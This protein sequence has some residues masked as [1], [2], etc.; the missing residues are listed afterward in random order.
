MNFK[1]ETI[2]GRCIISIMKLLIYI[3]LPILN[4]SGKIHRKNFQCCSTG[5]KTKKG[6]LF[7]HDELRMGFCTDYGRPMKPF[8]IDIRNFMA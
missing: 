8:F 1:K 3:V 7:D 5:R 2:S 6:L 4:V